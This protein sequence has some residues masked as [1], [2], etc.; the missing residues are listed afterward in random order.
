MNRIVLKCIIQEQNKTSVVLLMTGLFTTFYFLSSVLHLGIPGYFILTQIDHAV[1]YLPW[2]SV[3]YI[4]MYPLL[5]WIFYELQNFENQNKLLYSFCIL[6]VISNLIFFMYPVI[7][8]REFYPL[9]YE[10]NLGVNL[11][12]TIRFID[13]PVNCFPSLHVSSLFLF[14]FSLWTESRKK[15]F[16]SLIFTLLISVST[17]T[18]K[19]HYFLDVIAG[20]VLSTLIYFFVWNMIEI[21]K[22]N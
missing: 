20:I 12:R 2:T 21:K 8:P 6:M 10:N 1:P 19:Q 13:R 18:T 16:V 15:F 7:Y 5:F 17:M 14:S 9:P 11:L 22:I 4:M 3:I